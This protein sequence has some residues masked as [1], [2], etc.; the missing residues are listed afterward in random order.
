MHGV[1]GV[2]GVTH[3]RVTGVID[4]N[5]LDLDQIS[6]TRVLGVIRECY[7]GLQV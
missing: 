7:Q 6:V 1:T 2:T 4:E 5:A 3:V